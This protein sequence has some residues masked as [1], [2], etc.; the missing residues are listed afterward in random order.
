MKKLNIISPIFNEESNLKKFYE[1]LIIIKEKIKN[2]FEIKL[3]FVDDGSHDKSAE[4]IRNLSKKDEDLIGIYFTKNFGHQAAI[5][6]GLKEFDADY[7]AVLDADLQHNPELIEMML[8]NLIKNECEIIQMKKDNSNYESM[9]KRTVSKYF[10]LIFSK[11]TNISIDPGSSDFFL[12]TNNVRDAMIK[13]KISHNFIRGFLHWTGFKKMSINFSPEKRVKGESSYS[14]IKL[15]ELALTG[16]Y[17]YTTKL[18]I[19]IFIFAILILF[20]CIIF[21]VYIFYLY[22]AGELADNAGWS[23]ITILVLFFGSISLLLN[24]VLLFILTKIFDY[25]SK[26]PNYIKKFTNKDEKN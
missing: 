12:I 11:I 25:S 24:S 26:K 6:A 14:Y 21:S 18:F 17:F 4:I 20:V 5:F 16:F 1:S 22:F 23:T 2:N 8:D 19:Y 7:Y 3:I 15:L 13:S 10:Y 9:I